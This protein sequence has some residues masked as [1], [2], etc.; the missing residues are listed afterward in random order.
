MTAVLNCSLCLKAN[1][2]D[3][4]GKG[5]CITCA[6]NL[7]LNPITLEQHNGYTVLRDDNLLGGTKSVFIERMIPPG[8]SEVVY[9]SPVY[10]GFQIA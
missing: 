6:R 5:H 1:V 2:P 9:A 4:D 8:A 10:G 7:V 3:W